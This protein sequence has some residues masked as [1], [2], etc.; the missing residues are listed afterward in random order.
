LGLALI[1]LVHACFLFVGDILVSYALL[2]AVLWLLQKASTRHL[3]NGAVAALGLA[4]AGR[5]VLALV[6]GLDSP[7]QQAQLMQL[8]HQATAAYLGSAWDALTQRGQD[9]I[10]FY[11]LTP[12]FNW[13]TMLAM[14]L[15]GICAQREHSLATLQALKAKQMLP[16]A[17]VACAGN[18]LY[19][20]EH[21]LVLPQ[22][23]RL[24]IWAQEAL[25]APLLALC[26]VWI[27]LQWREGTWLRPALIACG[28]MS[29]TIYVGQALIGSLIFAHW[30]L[31]AFGTLSPLACLLCPILLQSLLMICAQAWLRK[32]RMGPDEWL[33]RS[34][35]YL[36]WQPFRR[37]I[38][39]VQT[40]QSQ[41]KAKA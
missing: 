35:T 11:L 4:V 12:L 18:A 32:W 27:L 7:V 22:A 2:G 28:R 9:L 33:L 16:L 6:S 13:P 23:D 15:L 29:L 8:Q 1:G 20:W 40:L 39:D 26:Y 36:A 34:W 31:R 10:V 25:T 5:L 19:A 24:L 37:V 14:A 41:T 21:L 30:G 3:L 17:A 38:P